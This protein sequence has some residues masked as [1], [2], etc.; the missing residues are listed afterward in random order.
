[1]SSVLSAFRYN[2]VFSWIVKTVL[3]WANFELVFSYNF[4]ELNFTLK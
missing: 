2:S 3:N 1:M 4:T